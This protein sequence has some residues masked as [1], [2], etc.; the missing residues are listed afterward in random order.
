MLCARTSVVYAKFQLCIFS[1][2]NYH[3]V[4]F[5]VSGLFLAFNY[6]DDWIWYVRFG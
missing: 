5:C 3:N 2:A 4:S 1:N 6:D